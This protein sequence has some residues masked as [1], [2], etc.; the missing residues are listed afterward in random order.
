M[1]NEAIINSKYLKTKN[2]RLQ[3]KEWA[4]SFDP[5]PK[6]FLQVKIKKFWIHFIF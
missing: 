1:L 3:H 5:S 6:Q 2:L 4:M